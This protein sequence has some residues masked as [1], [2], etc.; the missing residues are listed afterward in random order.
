MRIA[1]I[2][3]KGIPATFGGVE[4]H[5]QDLSL[6][7]TRRGHAVTVYSRAWYA[8][9][10]GPNYQGISVVTI[11]TLRTKHFDTITHTFFATIRAMRAH[12]DIIHY[13]GVGPAL[14]SFIPRYFAPGT[15][16][17]ATFHSIDRK[18]RKWGLIARTMLRLGE[19]AAC[20]WCST[21]LFLYE[22]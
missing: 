16:V 14:L 4:R 12:H 3:Q 10:T 19:W 21:L 9:D 20:T 15:T 7:L 2:G 22:H 1:M 5:V 17:I 18:H 13:H 11:P 8:P 6:E